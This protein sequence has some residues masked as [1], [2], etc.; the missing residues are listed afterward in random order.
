M[1]TAIIR[2]FWL[3]L[4]AGIANMAPVF[5]KKVPFLDKPISKKLFG[6]HK[7]Y[8]GFFFGILLSIITIY[9]QKLLYPWM[10]DYSIIDYSSVNV[11]LPGFLLGFGALAGD[12][13]K[14]YFKRKAGIE[15]GKAW[16]PFDQLDW[17]A[18]A[19]ICV[20][21][22]IKLSIEITVVTVV[23]FGL[24]HPAINLIGYLFKAKKEQF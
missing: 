16:I 12:L 14:S 18:G 19:L 11:L 17:I 7:T 5:F 20:A 24:L 23:L 3:F 9:L 10:A 2:A 4:P 15:P 21:F 6:E 13:V 8:R 22:Y 1:I